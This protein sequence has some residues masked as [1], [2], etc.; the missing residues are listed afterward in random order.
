MG[1]LLAILS[2]VP[3]ESDGLAMWQMFVQSFRTHI[4]DESG[5]APLILLAIV[6]LIVLAINIKI[7][8]RLVYGKPSSG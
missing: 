7:A 5:R 1:D 6:V 4:E 8:K 2:S 3:R